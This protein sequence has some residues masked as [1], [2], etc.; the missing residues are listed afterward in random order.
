VRDKPNGSVENIALAVR[1][2]ETA[3]ERGLCMGPLLLQEA[4]RI[5]PA[6]V[7]EGQ[8]CKRAAHHAHWNST[9]EFDDQVSHA[10]S[11]PCE[12][13]QHRVIRVAKYPVELRV[14]QPIQASIASDEKSAERVSR[15]RF[16]SQG[17]GGR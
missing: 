11:L 17:Q 8:H 6:V 12:G 4:F 9:R 5:H 16:N 2:I 13:W 10:D 3:I 1:H 15:P 14:R 7:V